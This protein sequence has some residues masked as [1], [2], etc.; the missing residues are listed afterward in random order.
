MF[1]VNTHRKTIIDINKITSLEPLVHKIQINY[2]LG[3]FDHLVGIKYL[4]NN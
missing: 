4:S 1:C 3:Q 2:I